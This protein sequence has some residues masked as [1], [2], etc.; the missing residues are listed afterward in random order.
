MKSIKM[1]LVLLMLLSFFTMSEV[2]SQSN[3]NELLKLIEIA[4]KEKIDLKSWKIYTR[5]TVKD[6]TN[7]EDIDKV[8]ENIKRKEKGFKW[9]V[10]HD[11]NKEHHYI[12]VGYK[13]IE[14]K[15]IEIQVKLTVFLTGNNKYRIYHS[16]EIKGGIWNENTWEYINTNFKRE[17]NRKNVFYT[18]TG[19]MKEE[20]GLEF[21]K[22]GDHLVNKFSGTFVEGLIEEDFVSL[23]TYSELFNSNILM[24]NDKK[25]NLQIGLRKNE[26]D[27]LIYVT[28]GTPIITLGY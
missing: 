10:L 6:I 9:D 17:I 21:S 3:R 1:L 12:V 27:N 4:E 19:T 5:K 2:N 25:I 7:E 26:K 24:V 28:I 8:L 18:L 15:D 11:E 13:Q 14:S 22:I 23:S 20:N 16:Y